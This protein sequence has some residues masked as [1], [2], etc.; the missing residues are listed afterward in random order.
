LSF[1]TPVWQVVQSFTTLALY[2]LAPALMPDPVLERKSPGAFLSA[3]RGHVDGETLIVS[4]GSLAG[5]VCWYFKRD[6]VYHL[7]RDGEFEY[8]LRHP[9]ARH[10]TLTPE[11]FSALVS[12]RMAASPDGR[13][14]LVLVMDRTK[15]RAWRGSIPF[16]TERKTNGANGIILAVY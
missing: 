2:C 15:E 5:S 11:S 13:A 1:T 16:P 3:S 14:N 10:R 9:D 12:R 7:G 6:D 4:Q 8:G